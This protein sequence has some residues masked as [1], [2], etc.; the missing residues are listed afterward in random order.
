[1]RYLGEKIPPL[2]VS[3]LSLVELQVEPQLTGLFRG[4]V[5]TGTFLLPPQNLCKQLH[6][7]I[8]V[9]D[10]ERYDCE[11]KVKKHNN[12]VGAPSKR[13]ELPVVSIQVSGVSLFFL[14]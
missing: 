12:D 8:D 2:Q 4:N 7:K 11:S 10:E 13:T 5:L 9:V 6:S 14:C 1:M 3:G